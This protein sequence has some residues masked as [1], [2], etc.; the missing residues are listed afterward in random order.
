ML[1][2]AN[3]RPD[4]LLLLSLLLVILLYPLLDHGDLGP[5]LLGALMFVPVVAAT[6]RLAQIRGRAWPRLILMTAV[7]ALSAA[8]VFFPSPPLIGI[9]WLLLMIFFA[10]AVV[11]LFLY[12]RDARTVDR[13]HLYTAASTYLLLGMVWFAFYSAVDTLSPGAIRLTSA[14][15]PDHQVELLYFSLVTL[16]TIGYGDVVP[17][18]GEVRIIAAME[19]IVGV[20]YIAITVALLV[21]AYRAPNKPD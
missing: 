6:I 4:L 9:R 8:S 15:S 2:K 13:A 3:S 10:M 20:L 1:E 21:G 14:T 19:G 11:R 17:L 5:L 16:S 7:L 12:L 18:N